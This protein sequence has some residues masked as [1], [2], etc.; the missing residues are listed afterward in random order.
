MSS[1]E[2]KPTYP[3]PLTADTMRSFFHDGVEVLHQAGLKRYD[4][5]SRPKTFDLQDVVPI[6]AQGERALVGIL[7][8]GLNTLDGNVPI[9]IFG[10]LSPDGKMSTDSLLVAN[11]DSYFD[12]PSKDTPNERLIPVFIHAGEAPKILGRSQPSAKQLGLDDDK[13]SR[14]QF[15]IALDESGQVHIEDL[16]S[17]NGTTLIMRDQPEKTTP[18]RRRALELVKRVGSVGTKAIEPKIKEGRPVTHVERVDYEFPYDQTQE[19]FELVHSY[20]KR[21]R[22]EQIL[23]TQALGSLVDFAKRLDGEEDHPR[24]FLRGT[25]LVLQAPVSVDSHR[26]GRRGSARKVELT[27]GEIP[28]TT[29]VVLEDIYR[30]TGSKVIREHGIEGG[31]SY[32]VCRKGVYGGYQIFL[33]ELYRVDDPSSADSTTSLRVEIS[34]ADLKIR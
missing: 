17:T 6:E 25:P 32:V 8:A 31:S 5:Q 24:S 34:E 22:V 16:G 21:S 9:T 20:S 1:A 12:E 28:T 26:Q 15:S 4:L 23:L 27:D 7:D 3:D 30:L 2:P 13:I 33:T 18:R 14:R 10:F 11:G 19:E 29:K